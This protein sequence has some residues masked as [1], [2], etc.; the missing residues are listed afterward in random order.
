M[1]LVFMVQ[2]QQHFVFVSIVCECLNILMIQII[3]FVNYLDVYSLRFPLKLAFTIALTT[4]CIYLIVKVNTETY[5]L[6]RL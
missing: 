4:Q 6:L 1:Q 5:E 3:K 2:T